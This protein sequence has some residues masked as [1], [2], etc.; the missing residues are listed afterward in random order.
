MLIDETEAVTEL[1]DG[2]EVT[3]IVTED[4]ELR[5]YISELNEYAEVI[6]ENTAEIRAKT[7]TEVVL[8]FVVIAFI[9]LVSGL[10]IT[11]LIRK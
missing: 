7:E 1:S 5:V 9:G 2:I 10:L 3:E 6:S 4:S 11:N 8:M